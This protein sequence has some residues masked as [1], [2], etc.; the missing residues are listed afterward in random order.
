VTNAYD[1]ILLHHGRRVRPSESVVNA[2]CPNNALARLWR[3]TSKCRSGTPYKGRYGDVSGEPYAVTDGQNEA[4]DVRTSACRG[5]G[6]AA[7]RRRG[8]REM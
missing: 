5:G 8:G 6:E 7:V 1:S 4:L 3:V 2:E